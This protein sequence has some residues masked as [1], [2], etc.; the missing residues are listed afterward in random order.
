[1]EGRD[2]TEICTT[3][4]READPVRSM[5]IGNRAE[6]LRLRAMEEV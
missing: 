4:L 1:M 5:N 6:W 2:G 3:H